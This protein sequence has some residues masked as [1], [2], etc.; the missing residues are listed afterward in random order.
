MPYIED[1]NTYGAES[2]L[3]GIG[4]RTMELIIPTGKKVERGDAVNKDGDLSDG[5]DLFGIV[6][7]S[8]DGTAAETKTAVYVLG[9]FIWDGINTKTGTVKADFITLARDKGMII[10]E[11]GGKE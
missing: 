4:H 10:K 11:L 8:A 9:E 1:G 3:S 2:L 6:G 5:T 7:I